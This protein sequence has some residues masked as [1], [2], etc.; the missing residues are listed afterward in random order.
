MSAVVCLPEK[1]SGSLHEKVTS[2]D[3]LSLCKEHDL[4]VLLYEKLS[5]NMQEV[6]YWLCEKL[7]GGMQKVI[8]WL[9]E[10]LFGSMQN[11]IYWFREKIFDIREGLLNMKVDRFGEVPL[12]EVL[13]P[14]K[15]LCGSGS[16]TE[17]DVLC[18]KVGGR[19]GRRERR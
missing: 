11:V 14:L 12:R 5:G 17:K 9:C 13:L 3:E 8:Y 6:I 7:P 2:P 4:F 10:K 1:M 15:W 19:G 16:P 18:V